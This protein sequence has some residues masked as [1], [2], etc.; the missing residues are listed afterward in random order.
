[1]KRIQLPDDSANLEL[2]HETLQNISL[3]IRNLK[4]INQSITYATQIND[5]HDSGF[6]YHLY[7]EEK[8]KYIDY[9]GFFARFDHF[10][11]LQDQHKYI[12]HCNSQTLKSQIES[13]V[14]RSFYD[15]HKNFYFIFDPQLLSET[16]QYYCMQLIQ[17]LQKET[18]SSEGSEDEDANSPQ[19]KKTN[20]CFFLKSNTSFHKFL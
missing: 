4:E 1:M 17:D 9:L 7:T 8:N 14:Q 12:L 5:V 16:N 3:S 11:S 18:I 10:K 15:F 6:Q 13:F 2:G 19:N 20:L